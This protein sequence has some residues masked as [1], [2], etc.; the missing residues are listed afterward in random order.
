M[1][2]LRATRD[3]L[4]WPNFNELHLILD[5]K[6][7]ASKLRPERKAMTGAGEEKRGQKR[8]RRGAE[9]GEGGG[10]GGRRREGRDDYHSNNQASSK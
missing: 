2:Q 9:G 6:L 5:Y 3:C 4:L 8:R 10:G 7:C 1:P